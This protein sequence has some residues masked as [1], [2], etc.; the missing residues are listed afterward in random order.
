[1]VGGAELTLTESSTKTTLE[2]TLSFTDTV[3]PE[4]LCK[5]HFRSDWEL[6]AELPPFCAR[7]HC[8]L[9]QH[10]QLMPDEQRAC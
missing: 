7:E 4:H 6:T 1:M 5:L 8:G 3:C 9:I 10:G 2:V